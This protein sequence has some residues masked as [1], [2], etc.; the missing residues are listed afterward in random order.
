MGTYIK[1]KI[2]S[3]IIYAYTQTINK[4]FPFSHKK[5]TQKP[6]LRDLYLG[7]NINFMDLHIPT[8]SI[9]PINNHL[10]FTLE[11]AEMSEILFNELEIITAALE[12]LR[13][14]HLRWPHRFKFQT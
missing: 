11:S 9:F 5:Q 14:S 12:I 7:R 2:C 8:F 13:T 1:V 6:T 10:H 3:N 4:S